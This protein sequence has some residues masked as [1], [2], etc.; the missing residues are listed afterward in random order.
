MRKRESPDERAVPIFLAGNW[1]L[2]PVPELSEDL[3]ETEERRKDRVRLLLDRYGILFRELLQKEFPSLR[4]ASIFRA[5]RIMEL[6][7]EVMAGIF[8]NGIP[9]LQ[10]ISQRS[11]RR[12][13]HGLP[14]DAVYWINATDPA[15]LCGS[16]LDSIRGILPARLISNHLVYRG[17]KLVMVAKRNGKDLT[18]HVPPDDPELSSYFIS[19]HH[20]LTRKFQPAKR[21][22]IET[23]NGEEAVKSPYLPALR[24]S[25]DVAVD[26]KD[27]TLYRKL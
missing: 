3:L 7:G 24:D 2:L 8:F 22:T 6:S 10:F 12:L 13:Q 16:Q 19:L 9:G 14:E 18:F 27:V 21:I 1:R 25:F 5:L 26:Y 20:L 4:W 17:T 11:F 23:I 15:S